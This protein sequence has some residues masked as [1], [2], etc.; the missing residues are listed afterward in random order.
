M[1]DKRFALLVGIADYD[2]PNLHDLGGPGSD[3]AKLKKVLEDPQ[4]GRFEVRQVVN[5]ACHLVA[6]EIEGFFSERVTDDLVLFYFAGHGIK[7]DHGDLYLACRD[8]TRPLLRATAISDMFVLDV[9]K[10][11]RARRQV[12]ILDCCFG[13]AFGDHELTR[14]DDVF[15]VEERFQG[16]GRVIL[17]ASTRREFAWEK[18]RIVRSQKIAAR[19]ESVFTSW[20]ITGLRT[21]DAAGDND[22]HISA[23]DLYDYLL[24]RITLAPG[25]RQ[26]PTMK[27][28]LAGEIIVADVPDN[29]PARRRLSSLPR[30]DL[31]TPRR[32]DLRPWVRIRDQGAEASNPA[33]AAVMALETL[34]ALKRVDV[35][36]SARYVYQKAKKLMKVEQD[37]DIGIDWS[38]LKRVLEHYGIA[39]EEDWPYESGRLQMPKGK[40][41]QALD[42]RARPYRVRVTPVRSLADIASSLSNHRPVLA[43]F[44]VHQSNWLSPEVAKREGRI[45]APRGENDPPLGSIATTIVDYDEDAKVLR[46]AHTW[47]PTWGIR[48]FGEMTIDAA[49]TMFHDREMWSIEVIRTVKPAGSAMGFD[50]ETPLEAASAAPSPAISKAPNGRGGAQAE[51]HPRRKAARRLSRRTRTT[52]A[53]VPSTARWAVYDSQNQTIDLTAASLPDTALVRYEDQPPSGDAAVDETYDAI[54]A[55]HAF[56]TDVLHRDSWDGKGSRLEAVIH[57]GRDFD[58]AFWDG[59]RVVL[60]DGDGKIFR[61]FHRP[62]V[63][64]KEMSM[65]YIL[66]ETGLPYEGQAGALV[67]SISLVFASLVMQYMHRQTAA[68]ASWLIGEGLL[69]RSKALCS[70]ADPGTAFDDPEIGKDPMV[71]HMSSYV[72][73]DQDNGGVHINSGIPNRAFVILARALGGH[74]WERAGLVWFGAVD[75]GP[76]KSKSPF[77]VFA[78]RTLAKAK[79]LFRADPAVAK[80]VS[81][82]WSQVGIKL[83]A[84]RRPAK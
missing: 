2:D 31:R 69:I 8:T 70:L 79:Q 6:R 49:R 74:A 21:G 50:W 63:I 26:T 28:D 44:S 76:I 4:I 59:S 15:D 18:D 75:D 36:L 22:K 10:S 14:A 32:S 23:R 3:V 67:H 35:R 39:P 1:A 71:G 68:R 78:R 45:E 61:A 5:K 54:A 37:S 72:K 34:L 65:G 27:G 53:P 9:M 33:V 47:G 48:G 43:A 17:T 30:S 40:T 41:W 13:G 80:A 29:S 20:I 77:R 62:D 42:R 81:T 7:N 64:A 16:E 57:Y 82:A 73:T 38:V 55:V 52:V 25:S 51:P 24:K 12:L 60:G 84:R 66:G 46:F 56:F 58:N 19:R 11:C 83:T